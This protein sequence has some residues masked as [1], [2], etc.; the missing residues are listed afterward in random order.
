[1]SLASPDVEGPPPP[2]A[3]PRPRRVRVPS[4]LLV[5]AVAGILAIIGF[6]VLTGGAKGVPVAVAARDLAGLQAVT[7]D[8]IRFVNVDAPADT[9]AGLV[10]R[11]D[12]DRIIGQLSVHPIAAG[13]VLSLSHFT[14]A[15]TT[16]QQRA[17]SL[18]VEPGHAV[19]G[20]LR[21]GD[22]VDVVDAS[23]DQPVYV[24]T[25]A[26]VLEAGAAGGDAKV[27]SLSGRYSVTIAVDDREALAVSAAISAGKIEVI[28]ATGAP[29]ITPAPPAPTRPAR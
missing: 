6:L 20:A 8:D 26:R 4:S 16:A 24:A 9:L 18:P 7:A 11:P 21:K 2:T 19:G 29:P 13:T 17:M 25:D 10:R 23:G 15:S 1:M 28:R 27:G 12:L 14:P 22:V 3:L 5:A